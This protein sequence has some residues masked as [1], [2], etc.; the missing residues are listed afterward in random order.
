MSL[1]LS[2]STYVYRLPSTSFGLLVGQ[3]RYRSSRCMSFWLIVLS[4][5][6]FHFISVLH[7]VPCDNS[8]CNSD[9]AATCDFQVVTSLNL[10]LGLQFTSEFRALKGLVF[11]SSPSFMFFCLLQLQKQKLA[12]LYYASVTSKHLGTSPTTLKPAFFHSFC[13]A[14]SSNCTREEKQETR[15][16]KTLIAPLYS[17]TT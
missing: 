17:A 15:E 7:F 3:Y 1:L 16:G 2:H 5:S 14:Y 4:L 11:T 10:L 6:F 8:N 12:W 13:V 9:W